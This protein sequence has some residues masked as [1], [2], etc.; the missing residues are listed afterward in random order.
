MKRREF[1][2]KMIINSSLAFLMSTSFLS[3]P[4]F[5]EEVAKA[6]TAH[7]IPAPLAATEIVAGTINY[8][9]EDGNTLLPSAD[10]S[11][12]SGSKFNWPA[13][14][15]I[16]GYKVDYSKSTMFTKASDRT[17]QIS[18]QEF[19]TS[20][21]LTTIEDTLLFLNSQIANHLAA[22]SVTLTYVYAK[23]YEQAENIIVKYVD[24]TGSQLHEPK[25]ISG[26]LG[27]PYAVDTPEYKLIL[28]GYTLDE[29]QLPANRFGI[30]TDE[31][32]TVTYIYIKDVAATGTV[33]VLY[34]DEA[35][36]NRMNSQ[37]F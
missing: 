4:V 29:A 17:Q 25:V 8:V 21:G 16:K 30:M 5:A 1:M 35:G 10:V 34:L 20:I 15:E 27:D 6:T 14:S 18:L 3:V 32:Q 26:Y 9:S 24:Q 7:A 12:T 33:R 22:E 2:F 19:M 11:T 37:V 23:T 28:D 36:Q 13:P 31:P